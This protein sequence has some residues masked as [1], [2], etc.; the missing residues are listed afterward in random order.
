MI[1]VQIDLLPMGDR[2]YPVG[3]GIL[4][5]ANVGRARGN[6]AKDGSGKYGYTYSYSIDDIV[7]CRGSVVHTRGDGIMPLLSKVTT[8]ITENKAAELQASIERIS[9]RK[10]QREQSREAAATA[11]F[12]NHDFDP[13]IVKDVSGWEIEGLNWRRNVFLEI[14]GSD[15]PS[16]RVV[17][18]VTFRNMVINDIAERVWVEGLE[19]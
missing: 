10:S 17:F 6:N 4:E 18:C 13:Y 5:I 19:E 9:K 15:E 3:I 1:R 16:T 12:V 8:D 7:A 11:L 14:E 2:R